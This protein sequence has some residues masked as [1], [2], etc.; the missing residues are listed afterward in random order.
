MG[1]YL[2]WTTNK[3]KNSVIFLHLRETRGT[4]NRESVNDFTWQRLI[5]LLFV[6]LFEGGRLIWI[7]TFF[8]FVY[9]F[10][11]HDFVESPDDNRIFTLKN[12]KKTTKQW[13]ST[14]TWWK[15][16]TG[17]GIRLPG[18]RVSAR[19]GSGCCVLFCFHHRKRQ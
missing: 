4:E 18:G 13:W 7:L 6:C 17:V 16:K 3:A 15:K 10:L 2:V 5:F 11:L 12:L 19:K 9:G 1:G 14:L 8:L